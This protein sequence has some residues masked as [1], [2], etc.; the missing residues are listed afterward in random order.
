MK[1][2]IVLCAVFAWIVSS[3]IVNFSESPEERLDD[4]E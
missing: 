2:I 1:Q 4:Y 3:K